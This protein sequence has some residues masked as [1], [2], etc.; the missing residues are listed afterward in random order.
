MIT[1]FDYLLAFPDNTEAREMIARMP[2]D[3]S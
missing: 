1:L 2:K 3:D